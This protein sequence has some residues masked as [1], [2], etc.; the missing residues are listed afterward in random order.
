MK[1]TLFP[2]TTLFRSANLNTSQ[3]E[4]TLKKPEVYTGNLKLS[5]NS[6]NKSLLEFFSS[7]NKENISTRSNLLTNDQNDLNTSLHTKSY[8]TQQ[9][10]LFTQQLNDQNAIQI[11]SSYTYNDSPQNFNLHP[12][13]DILKIG[14]A[15]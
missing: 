10:L 12:G 11:K 7:W 8:F 6:S 14:R 2:Y 13:L 9:Q 15:S 1:T 3:K 4:N 5:W